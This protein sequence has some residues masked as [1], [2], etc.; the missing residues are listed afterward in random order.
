MAER[1]YNPLLD[2]WVLCSKGRLKRP[3]LGRRDEI[4]RPP[5][6]SYGPECYI[7]PGNRRASGAR[8]PEY[9]D[10]FVF[11]NDF[12]PLVRSASVRKFLVGYELTSEPQRDFDAE[13]AAERLR[14]S[15]K[16]GL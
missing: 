5:T 9:E 16:P 10:V 4:K 2:E 8:N 1:R 11:D 6:S 14:A 15:G 7:Y 12:P 13:E 3:W